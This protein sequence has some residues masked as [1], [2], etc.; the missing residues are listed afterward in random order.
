ML[1]ALQKDRFLF[2]KRLLGFQPRLI[3]PS[4]PFSTKETILSVRI[5]VI[6]SLDKPLLS[7]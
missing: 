5:H 7:I 6:F 1:R 4:F 2:P 3:I